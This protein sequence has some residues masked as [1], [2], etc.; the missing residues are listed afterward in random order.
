MTL[1]WNHQIDKKLVQD[2]PVGPAH[3][4][5]NDL[6]GDHKFPWCHIFLLYF[7]YLVHLKRYNFLTVLNVSQ[8]SNLGRN[9]MT[10]N[11]KNCLSEVII[12]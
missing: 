5:Q 2:W 12:A 3:S 4:L 8:V 1:L 6:S 7:R 10:E 9:R 11:N